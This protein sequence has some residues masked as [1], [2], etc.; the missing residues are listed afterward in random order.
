MPDDFF[1]AR[2]EELQRRLTEAEAELREL[3]AEKANRSSS[4]KIDDLT[5]LDSKRASSQQE[6]SLRPADD[7][8][9]VTLGSIGDAVITTKPDGT[10]DF[11]NPVAE[12]LTGWSCADAIDHP[13]ESVFQ[14]V[15]EHTGE[16]ID[17]PATRCLQEGRIVGLPEHTV[18]ISKDQSRHPIDDSA[19][20]I[21]DQQGNLLGA[22][23]VFHDTTQRRQSEEAVREAQSRLESMMVAGEIG[24]WEYD[25]VTGRVSADPNL[26]RMFGIPDHAAKEGTLDDY[27]KVVH[28]D[29]R[30]AVS[31]AIRQTVAGK[32]P[33]DVTYRV[34]SDDGSMRWVVARGRVETDEDGNAR[35][36]PGVVVDITGQRRA[37]KELRASE[38]RWRLALESA[39][40]GAWSIDPAKSTLSTDERYRRIFT[41]SPHP[42][43]YE[44]AFA[45]IHPSDRQRIRDAVAAATCPANP[46]PFAE[47]YRVV[48]P[49]GTL[50]WVFGKGRSNFEIRAGIRTLVSFNGTVADITD[51]IRAEE[52]LRESA[53]H[54]RQLADA[55]PQLAWSARPDGN[56][57]WFNDRWYEY[58]GTTFEDM[59]GWKWQSVHDPDRL[60]SVLQRWRASIESGEPFSMT[61]PLRGADGI[62][63]EFLTRV[64][65]LRDAEGRITRWF[66]TNTDISEQHQMQEELRRIA[67]ELSESD[68]RKDEFLATLAH[69]LRNPLSPI[70]SATQLMQMI[71]DDPDEYRDLSQVIDRQVE[72]MVRLIDDLLDVSRISRGKIELRMETCDLRDIIHSALESTEPLIGKLG[73]SLHA[74]VGDSPLLVQADSTRLAQVIV[75]LLNNAAKYTPPGGDIWLTV[76]TTDGEVRLEVRDNGIGIGRSDL[77]TVF[78]MFYQLHDEKR[79]GQGGLGIGLSLVKSLVELHGG[80]IDA[81]SDG[82]GQGSSFTIRLPRLNTSSATTSKP[83]QLSRRK[84]SLR[85]FRILV[86]EDTRANRVLLVKLL[87]RLGHQVL[88]A[89]DGK[90]GL[91]KAAAFS[92]EIIFSD[93]SM[94]IMNGYEMARLIRETHPSVHLVALSGYGQ[95]SDRQAA[96]ESGFDSYI[97]KPVHADALWELLDGLSNVADDR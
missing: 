35:R 12:R 55:I 3:R 53:A 86:V 33:Y 83:D 81:I 2:C 14:I 7:L 15:D 68:R 62:Y 21:R 77:N 92:P 16:P 45:A 13:I 1:R 23:L 46:Q 42:L 69:E 37:E 54:F 11:L 72:Q 79:H 94:P 44:Q 74:D 58:T 51:R 41:G 90:D 85:S 75:N 5:D 39:E 56:I 95:E 76:G 6:A 64:M 30:D 34:F 9:R 91:E 17:N 70:K 28:P 71:D 38:E 67:A 84:R 4:N 47:E 93:I 63:R 31:E 18:L 10:I 20:P 8:L 97:V 36:L 32:V 29:D 87:Q 49:D 26:A 88:D 80:E 24:T 43:S 25:L 73:H 78:E 22:V 65:P 27:L 50:R 19:A 40:L 82:L 57:D 59:Q 96:I 52:A 60:P 66:G 48:H 89:C 61:F